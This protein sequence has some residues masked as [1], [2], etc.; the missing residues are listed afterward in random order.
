MVQRK[1]PRKSR[2]VF[3]R[4]PRSLTRRRVFRPRRNL[5]I[6]HS[7]ERFNLGLFTP[8]T[9]VLDL[10]TALTFSINQVQ[11]ITH[12]A[13]MYDEYRINKVILTFRPISTETTLSTLSSAFPGKLLVVRDYDDNTPLTS[14]DQYYQH[15]DCKMIPMAFNKKLTVALT[16]AV[17]AANYQSAVATAYGSKY[18][19]WLDMASTSVPHYGVKFGLVRNGATGSQAAW[20]TSPPSIEVFAQMYY[21]CKGQR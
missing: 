17:L 1:S 7:S 19:Q 12:L 21:S 4:K 5:G 15:K 9:N 13:G 10:H 18:K 3:R 11:N 20:P 8:A 14:Q 2:R 6:F 16:P